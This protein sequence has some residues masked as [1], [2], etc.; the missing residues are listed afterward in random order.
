MSVHGGDISWQTLRR[1]V[2]D[3]V[4]TAAELAE[5]QPLHGGSISTTVAIT[6]KAGDRAVLKISQHRVD[7]SYV[8][9]AYQLNVLRDIGLPAPQVYSCQV[10]TLD[11]P[12]SYLLLEFVHGVDLNEAKARLQPEQ[13]D[14]VQMHLAELLLRLH[15]QT[16]SHYTRLTE[17]HREEFESWPRFY[18]H[19]Y[20]AIWH[21]AEKSPLLPVKVRKQIAKCHEKLDRLLAHDDCPRLIH[22]DVWSSNVLVHHDGHGKWWVTGI[23]DPM[24]KYAHAESELAYLDLFRTSTP[25]LL[26]AYQAAHRLPPEYHSVRKPVY[27]MYALLNHFQLFGAEYLKPL[28]S[29]LEK[30]ASVS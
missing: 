25:A 12:V 6:T 15:A 28:L 18:R 10:G 13:F 19:C 22:G 1:I 5:V 20:D 14:H 2:H 27:Q 29:T 17:G 16:H 4:G 30:L 23:L 3:W 8:H 9:E 7:R 11:D 26:R 24:C 21:E